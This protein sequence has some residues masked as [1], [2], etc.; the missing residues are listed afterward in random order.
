MEVK[1]GYSWDK[2]KSK[3]ENMTKL[4]ELIVNLQNCDN[5]LQKALFLI[6]SYSSIE[7][8]RIAFYLND[9]FREEF[10]EFKDQIEAI[11]ALYKNYEK[12]GFID[13]VKEEDKFLLPKE[14]NLDSR[15]IVNAY[16]NDDDS[17]DLDKFF[18][19]YT[20]TKE[21]FR[22]CI[23]KVEHNDEELYGRY[24]ERVEENKIRAL[25]MPIYNVQSIVS[26]IETGKTINGENFDIFLFYRTA[27]F[28]NKD[29]D[30]EIRKLI[31]NY[32]KL[33]VFKILKRDLRN[34]DK[35][36]KG[37]RICSYADNLY[38]FTKCFDGKAAEVLKTWME[39][40]NVSTITPIHRATTVNC[41]SDLDDAE[42][43][44]EDAN[45]IFDTMEEV[46]Y[47]KAREMFD[48]LKQDTISKK[49][50]LKKT[51]VIDEKE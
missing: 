27:P 45:S 5:D 32:D 25:S 7:K 35:H 18:K 43:N 29:F 9:V 48:L 3:K 2:E 13:Y 44:R 42:F 23:S 41:Y 49:R 26:G 39:E 22:L 20:I 33:S 46:G 12:T 30:N 4:K 37:V 19:R 16:I 15:Y 17:Y 50:A 51:L 6:R 1:T 40:N 36:K 8:F 10:A 47:P 34:D 28:I 14:G 38:L 11:E 31:Q 21:T 24:L